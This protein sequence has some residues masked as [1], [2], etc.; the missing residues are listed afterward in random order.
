MGSTN[1]TPGEGSSGNS[2]P[3]TPA[4][5]TEAVATRLEEEGYE[6]NYRAGGL[7]VTTRKAESVAHIELEVAKGEKDAIKDLISEV[8]PS[9]PH[10]LIGPGETPALPD[11]TGSSPD[12]DMES[13]TRPLYI[14][15]APTSSPS[16][17]EKAQHRASSL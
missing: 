2:S 14:V 16:P 7:A 15:P 4:P 10:R 1:E 5:D 3:R 13:E 12:A 9:V 8:A 6:V 17:S 11:W